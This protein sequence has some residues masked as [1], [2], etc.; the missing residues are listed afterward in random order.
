MMEFKFKDYKF[1]TDCIKDGKPK[2]AVIMESAEVDFEPTLQKFVEDLK[3]VETI[4]PAE[5]SNSH[6]VLFQGWVDRELGVKYSIH[7]IYL[8]SQLYNI[9]MYIMRKEKVEYAFI[10][11][12]DMFIPVKI[13]ERLIET[14]KKSEGRYILTTTNPF[15]LSNRKMRPDCCFCY[16]DGDIK[17]LTECT[18]RSLREGHSIDKLYLANEFQ[19]G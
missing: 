7:N 16:S 19:K 5:R 9:Y 6:I 11:F 2:V 14:L 17:Q 12:F 1:N 15:F 18:D 13:A 4:P 3:Y 8:M 10:R